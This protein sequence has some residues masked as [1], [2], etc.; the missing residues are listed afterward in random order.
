MVWTLAPAL[1][2][3]HFRQ[4]LNLPPQVSARA[5]FS[6]KRAVASS[7]RLALGSPRFL[8]TPSQEPQL[9]FRL[10]GKHLNRGLE[11]AREEGWARQP[12]RERM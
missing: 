3:R 10:R 7:F 2:L 9:G 1:V 6:I 12:G 11:E 5:Y 8:L 4:T